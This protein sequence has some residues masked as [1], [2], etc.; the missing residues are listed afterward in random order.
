MILS[1]T[2]QGISFDSD[3]L[4]SDHLN[5]RV[6]QTLGLMVIFEICINKAV[7]LHPSLLPRI[8][9]WTNPLI[10]DSRDALGAMG[11]DDR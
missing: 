11:A 1:K 5:S 4:F 9:K 8:G 7:L 2:A 6:N 3:R 10:T